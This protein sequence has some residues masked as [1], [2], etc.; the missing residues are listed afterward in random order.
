MHGLCA[1][2]HINKL[3]N[4][5]RST[6]ADVSQTRSLLKTLGE[7]PDHESVNMAKARLAEIDSIMKNQL[8]EIALSGS[9]AKNR[10]WV[11]SESGSE[12]GTKKWTENWPAVGWI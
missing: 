5:M 8:D 12:S 4:R 9:G 1:Y 10:L 6:V 3:L 2:M 7:R 11:G